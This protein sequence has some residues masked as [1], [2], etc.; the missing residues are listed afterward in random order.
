MKKFFSTTVFILC[1]GHFSTENTRV[2]DPESDG[3]PPD[4]LTD[5]LKNYDKNMIPSARGIDVQMEIAIQSFAEIS[6]ISSSFSA[7][8]LFGEIWVDKRLEFS[9]LAP[10]LSNLTLGHRMIDS[11]FLPN[12]C[13]VNRYFYTIGRTLASTFALRPT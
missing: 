1:F 8:I 9:K 5:L 2:C 11:I 4:L 12:V 10:C 3:L 7:D 13:F 6:E